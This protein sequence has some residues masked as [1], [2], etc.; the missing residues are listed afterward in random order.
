MYTTQFRPS[1]LCGD[2]LP[3]LSPH[4]L[5]EN[6]RHNT[7]IEGDF[8]G[9]HFKLTGGG[10]GQPYEGILNCKLES[11]TGPVPFSMPLMNVIAIFGYPHF[12]KHINAFDVFKKSNG[13]EYERNIEFENGGNMRSLHIVRFNEDGKIN[14]ANGNFSVEAKVDFPDDVISLDPILETFTPAGPGRVR[15]KFILSWNRKNGTK[16]MASCESEYRLRHNIELPYALFRCAEFIEDRSNRE[17]LDLDE[18][19]W[20]SNSLR[21]PLEKTA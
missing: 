7:T 21:A 6:L 14:A 1:S 10:Y 8:N 17:T 11:E 20:V 12:S 16:T 2:I 3:A 5:P 19:I 9:E 13:Y 15:S 4:A 18:R